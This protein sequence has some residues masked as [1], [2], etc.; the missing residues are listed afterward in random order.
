MNGKFTVKQDLGEDVDIHGAGFNLQGGQYKQMI[1]KSMENFCKSVYIEPSRTF[2]EYYQSHMTNP[3]PWKTCPY[4]AGENEVK[5][6][7]VDESLFLLPPYIPGGEKWKIEIRFSRKNEEFFGGY[8]IYV[9]MRS[10]NSL[11][12]NI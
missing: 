7:L 8:N 4:P 2:F 1:E 9:I 11:L 3:V 6:F 10:P 5:N 12:D